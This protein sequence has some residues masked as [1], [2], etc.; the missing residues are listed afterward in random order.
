MKLSKSAYLLLGVALGAALGASLGATTHE[1]GALLPI[2][3]GIGIMV[4]NTVW[5]R[6]FMLRNK[7][8]EG[9]SSVRA[10]KS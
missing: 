8:L 4:A 9:R 10:A 3:M 2:G 7:L 1:M 5:N 6:N